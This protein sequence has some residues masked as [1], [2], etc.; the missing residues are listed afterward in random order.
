MLTDQIAFK[1]RYGE[2]YSSLFCFTLLVILKHI[3]ILS[4]AKY[5]FVSQYF[6]LLKIIL[7]KFYQ[8]LFDWICAAMRYNPELR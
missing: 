7:N 8:P 2:R 1:D 4:R 5:D 3:I 6:I